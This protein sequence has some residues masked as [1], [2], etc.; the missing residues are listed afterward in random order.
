MNNPRTD[1]PSVKADSPPIEVDGA[2]PSMRA[3]ISGLQGRESELWDFIEH[4]AVA[5]QWVGED[6]TILWANEAELRL[7]GYSRG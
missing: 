7:L 4:A 6:G 5:L 1:N 3:L 2:G